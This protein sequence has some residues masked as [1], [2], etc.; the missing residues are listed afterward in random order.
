LSLEHAPNRL[1]FH[2]WPTDRGDADGICIDDAGD[3]HGPRRRDTLRVRGAVAGE[4]AT[5][6]WEHSGGF[7]LPE[8]VRVVVH[9]LVA[10]TAT[11][12]GD[13]VAVT[14][15]SVECRPFSELRLNGVRSRK[16]V[17]S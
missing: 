8:L 6:T 10:E 13:P 2:C 14:G 17:R 5:V 11:A 3:G 7:P 9:G 4:T 1:T 16:E 12:D 15:S